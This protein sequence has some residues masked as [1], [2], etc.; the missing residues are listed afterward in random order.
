MGNPLEPIARHFGQKAAILVA[1]WG[2]TKLARAGIKA[3]KGRR[4]GDSGDGADAA[5]SSAPPGPTPGP[6]STAA[7]SGGRGGAAVKAGGRYKL[8]HR[9]ATEYHPHNPTWLAE[10]ARMDPADLATDLTWQCPALL[11]FQSKVAGSSSGTGSGSQQ[12][13]PGPPPPRGSPLPPLG[14]PARALFALEA[15]ACYLNHGSYGA[16]LR[17]A[18]DVRAWYQAQLE[19]QPVRFM[20]TTALKALV[21]AVADAARFVGA[22]PCDVVPAPN[23][24]TAVNAVAACV[25]LRRGDWVLMTNLTYPAVKSTLARVAAAAGASL[26]EVQ[27]GLEELSRPGAV[28][29]AVQTALAAGGRRIRLAVIDHVASFPPVVLPVAAITAACKQVGAQVLVDGAHALGTVPGLKVPALGADYYVANLHKWGCSPKGA[30]LLWAAPERQG[31]LRPLVTSHGC[32]LGWRAE[33]LWQ[34]TLDMSS[35]LAVPAALAVLRAL[36]PDRTARRSADLVGRAADALAA[37]WEAAAASA[38]APASVSAATAPL[39]PS[40][41]GAANGSTTAGDSA[42]GGASSGGRG[43]RAEGAGAGRRLLRLGGGGEWAEGGGAAGMLALELPPLEGYGPTAPDAGR[44]QR[45]LRGERRIEVPVIAVDGRLFV[46]ISGA[47]Y[48]DLSDYE[49]L[50]EAIQSLQRRPAAAAP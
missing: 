1:A 6:S 19:A 31:G 10:A 35:W 41:A 39:P 18:L 7:P 24:T 32:G 11:E 33:F 38:T 49:Q 46:R 30:A 12:Q 47:I 26:I 50:G 44:L 43:G 29:A 17:L 15:G 9:P 5:A 2:I 14:L 25:P 48:N 20:E 28:L 34:G 23:A 27:L 13:A 36:G 42:N 4:S 45:W 22:P 21:A 8:Y 16:A 3:L 40:G 37:R